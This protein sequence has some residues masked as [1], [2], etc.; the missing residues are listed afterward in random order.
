MY[1]PNNWVILKI[2]GHKEFYKVLAGWSSLYEDY[3]R[4]NSGINSVESEYDYWIFKGESGSE[5]KCHKDAEGL[6]AIT[7]CILGKMIY[8]FPDKISLVLKTNMEL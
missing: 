1:V 5:Y 4:L 6:S 7:E 3:W 8:K 2:Q